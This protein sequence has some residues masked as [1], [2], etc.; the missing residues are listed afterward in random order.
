VTSPES[1]T[2]LAPVQARGTVDVTVTTPAGTSSA[3]AADQFTYLPD[4]TPP[5]VSGTVAPPPN[6]AGWNTTSPATVNLLATDELCG[7]GVNS[8][9][10][11]AFGAEPIPVTSVIGTTASIPITVDGV[12]TVAFVATD[13]AG[14]SSTVQTIRVRLDTVPP[15]VTITSPAA[16]TY[17]LNQVVNAG[18]SCTDATSGVATCVGTVANGNPVNTSTLGSNSFSVNASDV[19]GN[20]SSAT[21]TYLVA[22]N[23][24][25]LYNPAKGVHSGSTVPIKLQICDATNADLSSS[26]I[27]LTLIGVASA[28]SPGTIVQPLTGTFRFDPTLPGYITNVSTKGLAPGSYVLEFTISGSDT[29]V[30][31]APF[32]VT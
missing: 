4:T 22:Y 7:S 14:N 31:T 10:Y 24:C 23:I 28:S 16:T 1:L 15:T 8:I 11:L 13:N 12:T 25:L 9:T 20:T 21:V 19:A 2:A 30:H 29:T 17:L 6:L 18:Y 3:T 27:T 32:T 26:T 5:S